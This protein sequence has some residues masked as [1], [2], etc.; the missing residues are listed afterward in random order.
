[1]VRFICQLPLHEQD[2]IRER[3]I[4]HLEAIEEG[5]AWQVD[6]FGNTNIENIMN[7]TICNLEGT[8]ILEELKIY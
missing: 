8:G 1:M 5:L 3:V 4:E 6:E 7:D 2:R